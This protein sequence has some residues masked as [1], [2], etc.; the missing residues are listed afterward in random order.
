MRDF[1]QGY[2]CSPAI[3]V[4]T[5]AHYLVQIWVKRERWETVNLEKA[6]LITLRTRWFN[7]RWMHKNNFITNTTLSKKGEWVLLKIVVTPS[8]GAKEAVISLY[9]ESLTGNTEVWLDNLS[10]RQII[11]TENK[12]N[13]KE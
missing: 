12:V 3:S 9:P 5:R 11:E 2:F 10:F 8:Q 7:K 4:I 1:A 13:N 6:L